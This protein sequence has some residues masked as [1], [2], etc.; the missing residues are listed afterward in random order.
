M[1]HR[2]NCSVWTRHAQ[3][4]SG[5]LVFRPALRPFAPGRPRP[6]AERN[7][8]GGANRTNGRSRGTPSGRDNECGRSDEEGR[9]VLIGT[10]PGSLALPRSMILQ[11]TLISPG[12]TDPFFGASMLD[13]LTF[14]WLS[15]HGGFR[16]GGS[17]LPARH[18]R[19]SRHCVQPTRPVPTGSIARP[20]EDAADGHAAFACVNLTVE[21]LS[22]PGW[23][24]NTTSDIS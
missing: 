13:P 20:A 11:T 14:V 22:P 16:C 18:E 12:S 5:W 19:Q 2:C 1:R 3:M 24:H 10:V 4:F 17:E 23:P 21:T 7:S 8:C 15:R 6:E 9:P